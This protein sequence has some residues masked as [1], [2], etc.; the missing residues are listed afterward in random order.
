MAS[1]NPRLCLE[2]LQR[3]LRRL[4]LLFLKRQQEVCPQ[5]ELPPLRRQRHC[6]GTR[7]RLAQVL[8]RLCARLQ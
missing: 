7:K 3:L 6:Q 8:Q 4:C 5:Q 2:L 1:Q